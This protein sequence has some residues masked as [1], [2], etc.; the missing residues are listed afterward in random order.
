MQD[1]WELVYNATGKRINR[2]DWYAVVKPSSNNP[3]SAYALPRLLDESVIKYLGTY[4]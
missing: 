1:F 3:D 2:Q 4:A